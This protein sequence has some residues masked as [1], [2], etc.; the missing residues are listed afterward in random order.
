MSSLRKETVYL[1]II[2]ISNL[3]I[4]LI[5]LPYL[6]KVLGLTG[7]GKLGLAQTVFFLM[8]F[9]IDFGFTY[10]ASRH[11][12]LEKEDSKKVNKIYTNVQ[13]L[14][15]I[16]YII[17]SLILVFYMNLLQVSSQDKTTYVIALISSFSFLL[18][19]SWLFNGLGANSTLAIFTL[20]FRVLTL[21]P[22]FLLVN[23][24]K[25]YLLAFIIQNTSLLLLGGGISIYL[26]V[27]LNIRLRFELTD[28]IYMKGMFR[29]GFDAFSGS[30]LSVV[31]TT[32]VPFIVKLS[33]GDAFVGIYILVER[34]LSVLKQLFMPIIQAYYSTICLMYSKNNISEIN[35]INR[36]IVAFYSLLT[37]LALLFN[38][39]FGRSLI[40]ILFDNQQI[41][42]PYIFI[43]IIGQFVVALSIVAIYGNILPSGNGYIL[44]RIYAKWALLFCMLTMILWDFLS[45]N[46]IYTLVIGIEIFI[47][48]EA[49]L[50]LRK[51]LKMVDA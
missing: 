14:R 40:E 20:S 48:I 27:K 7:F 37:I 26:R 32:G 23:D 36:K 38:Y 41:I 31:Y 19:P 15:L 47:V 28:K 39:L 33:L 29:E 10:S 8:G 6:T 21:I 16:I 43:S 3:A 42:Y 50:F 49:T 18:I 30:A 1:Y 13:L 25:D 17:V 11:I 46:I 4:P 45:L 2:Q 34:V 5:T 9:L 24:T 22:I 35:R 51:T 44:K 12:S